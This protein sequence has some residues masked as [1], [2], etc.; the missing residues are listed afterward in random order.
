VLEGKTQVAAVDA[1][2]RVDLLN[3]EL[4]VV[5]PWRP[6]E[7]ER[8]GELPQGPDQNLVVSDPLR[9]LGK[10]RSGPQSCN[11]GGRQTG[12]PPKDGAPV[13]KVFVCHGFPLTF[14]D[15]EGAPRIVNGSQLCPSAFGKI[16]YP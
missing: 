9:R 2:S 7:R 5:A 3:G 16:L 6:N 1:A 13:H 14:R 15:R 8:A 12:H 4:D 10:Q 11:S